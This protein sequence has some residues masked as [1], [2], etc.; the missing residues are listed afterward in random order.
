[1][2]HATA[3]IT[4]CF[5]A[6]VNALQIMRVGADMNTDQAI[7]AI[8]WFLGSGRAFTGLHRVCSHMRKSTAKAFVRRVQAGM[9][10]AAKATRPGAECIVA[11]DLSNMILARAL[12]FG[13]LE[14]AADV[15]CNHPYG[16]VW[17]MGR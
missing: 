12:G 14:V 6:F 10:E 11:G 3:R 15:T 17:T 1:M 5:E 7:Y 8:L 4:P 2:T 13:S 9:L 16:R